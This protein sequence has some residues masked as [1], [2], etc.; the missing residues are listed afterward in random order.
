MKEPS[1]RRPIR[2]WPAVVILVIEIGILAWIWL[3]TADSTQQRVVPTFPTLFFGTVALF[4][5]LVLFS[6]LPG[7]AR[8]SIFVSVMGVVGLGSLLFEIKGVDGNLVPVVG[9]RWSGERSFEASVQA[10]AGVTAAGPNDYPQ[11]YGPGRDA[12]LPGPR[13]AR[14]WEA[15]PPRE[16]WRRQVG[17]GWSSFAVVGEAAVT[18]EQRGDEEL[19][20]RYELETGNQVWL[21]SDSSPFNTTVG[22]SG[23]RTTP[24]IVGDRVYSLG[25]SGI[26]NCLSLEDG[27]RIWSRNVLEDNEVGRPDWGMASSP[28]VVG[29]VVI[30]QLGNRGTSL[31]AY[32]RHSG[33]P[34]WVAGNDR[35]TYTSPT[36][37]RVTGREQVLIV[38]HNTVV[39]HDPA[40]GDIL[41]R[42]NWSNPGT[43]RVS[44]PLVLSGDRLLVSAGYGVGSKLFR[45]VSQG[46]SVVIEDLWESPRLKSKFAPMV[47]DQGVVYGLDDGVLVALDP[48]TGERLWKRGRYGHGQL[49]LVADLLLIQAE[50]GDVVLV[51]A[52]AE[53][54]RELARLSALKSKTWNPPALSGRLLLVR[55]NREAACYE[56]P[57]EN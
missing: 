14:D 15:E 50:N 6:R 25:A 43:E 22:G 37:A 56:L 36:L 52:T 27:Q 29:E 5:W 31:V 28:L 20:V 3:R 38:N 49:I 11:F 10:V 26:L 30:V 2:W 18:Q 19:V 7:R 41:W 42:A 45:V 48:E 17:E 32:D 55:N 51:E 12:T 53:E 16:I 46:D 57:V 13:L 24:T 4:L 44:M 23:P 39:G 40:T 47:T 35:G 9:Y 54:H 21:H 33:D 34:V 8:L 1:Q